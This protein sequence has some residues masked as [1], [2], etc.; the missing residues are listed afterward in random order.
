[1]HVYIKY[2]NRFGS[3]YNYKSTY[4]QPECNKFLV[5]LASELNPT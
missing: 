1:M 5:N 3:T 4:K 2:N